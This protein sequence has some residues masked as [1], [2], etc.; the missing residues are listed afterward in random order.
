MKLARATRHLCL[1]LAGV[2]LTIPALLEAG[3]PFAGERLYAQAC[4]QCHGATGRGSMPGAPDFSRRAD[5]NNG[6]MKGDR[7]LFKRIRQGGTTCPAFRSMFTESQILDIIAH[8][9]RLQR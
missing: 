7:E 2:F 4:A 8:L 5:P 3:D 6:L 9:R 1:G